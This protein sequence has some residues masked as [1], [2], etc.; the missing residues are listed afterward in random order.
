M[1]ELNIDLCIVPF[2]LLLRNEAREVSS[3]LE[4]FR[5]NEL[6]RSLKE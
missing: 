1:L 3:L 2:I 6:T 4:D 5:A